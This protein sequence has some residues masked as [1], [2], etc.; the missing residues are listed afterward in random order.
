MRTTITIDDEQ[1]RELMSASPKASAVE[2]IR[3]AVEEKVRRQ[4]IERFMQLA[5]SAPEMEDWRVAE[6]RE[7]K[8]EQRRNRSRH[9]SGR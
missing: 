5:G 6:D 4:R 2:I 8:V 7:T 1:M 3:E 9:G